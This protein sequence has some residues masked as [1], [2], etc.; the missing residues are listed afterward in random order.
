V[1]VE[2]IGRRP[3]WPQQ[4]ALFHKNFF[5]FHIAYQTLFFTVL[6]TLSAWHFAQYRREANLAMEQPARA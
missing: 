3:R 1:Q 5:V 6:G 4:L 2:G